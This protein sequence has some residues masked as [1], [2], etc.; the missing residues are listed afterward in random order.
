MEWIQWMWAILALLLLIA[1]VFVSGFV[2]IFFCFAAGAAAA[3]VACSLGY[4]LIWQLAAFIAATVVTVLLMP[5]GCA[6]H[7]QRRPQQVGHRSRGG[8]RGRRTNRD[9]SLAGARPRA[10]ESR[11]VASHLGRRPIHSQGRDRHGARRGRAR[12][13]VWRACAIEP[14]NRKGR[15]VKEGSLHVARV[16]DSK[17]TTTHARANAHFLYFDSE[18]LQF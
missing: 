8:Q 13:C 16:R 1:E 10:R 9:R 12:A 17:P 7:T 14:N 6:P 15:G 18:K 3:A 5:A 11:R 2:M 4:D